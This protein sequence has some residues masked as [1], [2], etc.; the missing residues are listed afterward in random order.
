MRRASGCFLIAVLVCTAAR[1]GA[2]PSTNAVAAE[3]LFRQGRVLLAAHRFV[4]ACEK[5]YASQQL[6]PAVGTLISLGECYAGQGRNASAWLA[7]REAS[8]LAGQR[9]DPRMTAAREKAAA[10]E[11]HI[12]HL[13]LHVTDG[14]SAVQVSVD[15]SP[16]A[17]AALDSP[18]PVDPG[19]HGV[20]ARMPLGKSWSAEVR[21]E[22]NGDTVD[23]VIPSLLPALPPVWHP[24]PAW[25]RIAGFG[26]VAA[27]GATIATGAVF[28][29]QA[30]VKARDVRAACPPGPTC[31]DASAVH[32]HDLGDT[33]ADVSTTLIPVGLAV[34]AVGAVVLLTT[35]GTL[36]PA[37]SP[38]QARL[39]A[40]WTW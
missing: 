10:L 18:L 9:N 16:I 40:R 19:P 15:G 7:Y 5:F 31:P 35:H 30:I 36:E 34:A 13:A 17:A 14:N 1:A 25:K 24:P 32:A 2:Q 37:V 3:E 23:V 22:S 28:G 8:S 29:M 12:A 6:E 27:G 39:D 38:T 11:T 33:F 4:Q 21:V 20:E 26:M